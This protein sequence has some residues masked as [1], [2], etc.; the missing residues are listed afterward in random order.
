MSLPPHVPSVSHIIH[1]QR[2]VT[3]TICYLTSPPHSTLVISLSHPTSFNCQFFIYSTLKLPHCSRP[4]TRTLHQ[5]VGKYS[6]MVPCWRLRLCPGPLGDM[7]EDQGSVLTLHHRH[8]THRDLPR[9]IE[10]GEEQD[11]GGKGISKEE[12]GEEEEKEVQCLKTTWWFAFGT[13]KE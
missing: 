7:G 12:L 8:V 4:T 5:Y 3:L 9:V 11:R 2:T 10:A 1:H 6:S 13:Y